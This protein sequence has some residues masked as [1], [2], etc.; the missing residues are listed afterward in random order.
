MPIHSHEY[1]PVLPVN[2]SRLYFFYKAAGRAKNLVS[3][4][5]ARGEWEKAYIVLLLDL[6]ALGQS[7]KM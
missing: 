4:D 3:G 5:E 1:T 6:C 7:T 2:V